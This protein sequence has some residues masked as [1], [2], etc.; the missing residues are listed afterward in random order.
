MDVVVGVDYSDF[1]QRASG[2]VAS[3]EDEVIV[4][5]VFLF[6]FQFI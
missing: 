4:N 5:R 1:M 2:R 6:S 3:R